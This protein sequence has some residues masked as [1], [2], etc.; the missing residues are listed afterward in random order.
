M[1]IALWFCPQYGS[2][3]HETLELLIVSLQSVFPSSPTFEPHIT[4]TNN[5][6]CKDEDDVNRILTSCV[7]AVQSIRTSVAKSGAPLVSFGSCSVGKKF[8]NKVVLDCNENR[9]LVSIAQIMRELYVEVDESSRSQRAAT[10]VRDEFRPHLSL[11]YSE[12]YPISQAFLRVVQQRVEDALDV[13]MSG[14][15]QGAERQLRWQFRRVPACSWG[16]PGTFKVVRCEGPVD[17]WQVL[18]RADV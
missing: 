17:Q 18:G 12:T 7:A 13:Q 2:G 5:L 10:W 1:T 14:S 8:F 11:L 6:V 15:E 9:Y 4:V 16:L 3:A